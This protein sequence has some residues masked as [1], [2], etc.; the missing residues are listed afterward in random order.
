MLAKRGKYTLRQLLPKKLLSKH[1][2]LE[3][4]PN[5]SNSKKN[6]TFL[7]SI[8]ISRVIV[9]YYEFKKEGFTCLLFLIL[10]IILIGN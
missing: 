5:S 3:L 2:E 6:I 10:K 8:D 9:F 4:I 7:K 1:S